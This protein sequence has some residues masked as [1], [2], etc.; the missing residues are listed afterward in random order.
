MVTEMI[1]ELV[2]FS[3]MLALLSCQLP[4]LPCF[5]ALRKNRAVSKSKHNECTTWHSWFTHHILASVFTYQVCDK[6]KRYVGR[7]PFDFMQ[8]FV[9]TLYSAGYSPLLALLLTLVAM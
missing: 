6:L 4:F 9:A 5:F 8:S 3:R 1:E 2:S 7:K